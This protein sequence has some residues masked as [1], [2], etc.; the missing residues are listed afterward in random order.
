MYKSFSMDTVRQPKILLFKLSCEID[1]QPD[2]SD[3]NSRDPYLSLIE[4][5]S[6]LR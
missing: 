6:K 5:F 3:S 4:Q 2:F 1:L